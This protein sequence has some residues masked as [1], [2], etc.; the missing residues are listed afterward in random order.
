MGF[1]IFVNGAVHTVVGNEMLW[2]CY[3][4]GSSPGKPSGSRDRPGSS[5]GLGS[6]SSGFVPATPHCSGKVPPVAPGNVRAVPSLPP[7]SRVVSLVVSSSVLHAQT[8]N[9]AA[10]GNFTTTGYGARFASS[11]ASAL[12]TPTQGS[13]VWVTSGISPIVLSMANAFTFVSGSVS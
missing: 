11:P 5:S 12:I 4:G 6:S 2:Q 8:V 9:A 3:S 13:A 1:P 10:H 7:I